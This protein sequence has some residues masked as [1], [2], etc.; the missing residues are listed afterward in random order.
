L[1]ACALL[2]AGQGS[3]F[4]YSGHEPAQTGGSQVAQFG[5][6]GGPAQGAEADPP[7]WSAHDPR[8]RG[9]RAGRQGAFVG[10]PQAVETGAATGVLHR[11]ADDFRAQRHAQD[12]RVDVAAFRLGQTAEGCVAARG[13]RLSARSRVADAGRG[14]HRFDLPF[15]CTEQSGSPASRRSGSPPR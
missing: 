3:P 5:H 7:G 1:D 15:G 12:L 2:C 13:N 4:L 9:R 10:E 14:E 6:T 11:R 8:H